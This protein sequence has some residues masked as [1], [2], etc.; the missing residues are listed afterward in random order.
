MCQENRLAV[1][2]ELL[3]HFQKSL[4]LVWPTSPVIYLKGSY[5]LSRNDDDVCHFPIEYDAYFS[6]LVGINCVDYDSV[7]NL[8]NDEVFLVDI[9]SKFEGDFI[10]KQV[11][12]SELQKFGI[13]RVL[14]QSELVSYLSDQK[15]DR[16]FFNRGVRARQNIWS[17]FWLPPQLDSFSGAFDFDSLYPALNHCR[18]FKNST[19]TELMREVSLK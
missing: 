7:I 11:T 18:S 6:Y 2:K 13:S 12:P 19:E 5:H 15:V 1:K 10:H 14:S 16:I 8:N 9:H 4:E 3:S 17:N